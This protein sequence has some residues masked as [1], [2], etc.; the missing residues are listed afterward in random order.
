MKQTACRA[1]FH[2]SSLFTETSVDFHLIPRRYIP[3]DIF[4][5]SIA[6]DKFSV[7]PPPLH[8]TGVVIWDSVF[9]RNQFN[10]Q[11]RETYIIE[12]VMTSH[13]LFAL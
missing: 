4:P 9:E 8:I 5:N 3:D 10:S 13:Y 11:Y 7:L 1:Q 2:A 12:Q 6:I